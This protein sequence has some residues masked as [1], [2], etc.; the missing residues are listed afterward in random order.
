[1]P[2]LCRVGRRRTGRS[3]LGLLPPMPPV[4]DGRWQGARAPGRGA[5][6]PHRL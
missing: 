1:M 3:P 5:P 4:V 6:P 2:P